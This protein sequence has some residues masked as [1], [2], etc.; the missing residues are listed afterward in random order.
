M[1]WRDLF[2]IAITISY[3]TACNPLSE[4]QAERTNYDSLYQIGDSVLTGLYVEQARQRLHN[5]SLNSKVDQQIFLLNIKQVQEQ[6]DRVVY[7]DTIIRRVRY[8]E[9]IKVDTIRRKVHIVDT[10]RDTVRVSYFEWKRKYKN[11]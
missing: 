10:I 6:R 7:K 2:I 1:N 8:K 5:D 9:I 11:K 4:K 3:L